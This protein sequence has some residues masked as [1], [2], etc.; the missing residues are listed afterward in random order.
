MLG[1]RYK[2]NQHG[3]WLQGLTGQRATILTLWDLYYNGCA[4]TRQG[5]RAKPAW[6]DLETMNV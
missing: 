4:H 6:E 2:Q 1:A 5:R 3:P